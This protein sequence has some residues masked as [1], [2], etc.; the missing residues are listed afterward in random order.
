MT[1]DGEFLSAEGDAIWRDP[2]LWTDLYHPDAAFVAWSAGHNPGVTFDLVVREAP[3]GGAYLTAAGINAALRFIAGFHY[4]EGSLNLLRD[5]G[6][7]EEYLSHLAELRFT[8][9]VIAI[10]EGRVVFPGEPLLRV[11]APFQ[12]ALLVESGILQAVNTATLIATKATRVVYAAAGRPVAE[13]GFRRAHSPLVATYAARIGGCAST[14]FLAAASAFGIPSSGTIPHALVELF[15]KEEEAFR[16]VA[17]THERYRLLLDTYDTV[18]AAETAVRVGHWA[19]ESFHHELAAVRLDSGDLATLSRQVRIILDEGGFLSTQILASGDLDEWTIAELVHSGA[20]IDAFG[21]GT[22]LV[23]GVGSVDHQIAGGALGGVYKL[24]WVE[25]E[26][27]LPSHA[28]LKLAGAKS[29]LPGV[30][31]VARA[32]DF[33]RDLILLESE[34]APEG[35]SL[36]LQPAI[37]GG[38]LLEPFSVDTIEAASARASADLALLPVRW[39]EL[40]PVEAFPVIIGPRLEEMRREATDAAD[41][42]GEALG[43]L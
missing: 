4:A 17:R 31:V 25:A 8:G 19:R 39:R 26:N 1:G 23:D 3:F 11:C 43:S 38:Q 36:L 6:Y 20:P 16:A 34:P 40:A 18:R 9:D 15:D 42:R 27:A 10:P 28:A 12:E 24:A 5:A 35:F 21:V 29:T 37:A 14:S 13:F 30:K 22:A 7:P 33:T 41:A 2:G 32:P